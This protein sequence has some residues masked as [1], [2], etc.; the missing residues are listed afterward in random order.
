[1]PYHDIEQLPCPTCPLHQKCAE[2]NSSMLLF[3]KLQCYLQY[4]ASLS[5]STTTIIAPPKDSVFF[6]HQE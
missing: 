5:E 6:K 3:N 1:M 4:L 2:H